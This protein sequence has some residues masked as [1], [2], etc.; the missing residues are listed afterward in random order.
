MFLSHQSLGNRCLLWRVYHVSSWLYFTRWQISPQPRTDSD[1]VC[2]RLLGSM[3]ATQWYNVCPSSIRTQ[4]FAI[5]CRGCLRYHAGNIL[6]DSG[7]LHNHWMDSD[8]LCGSLLG[9]TPATQLYKV[10]LCPIETQEVAFFGGACISYQAGDIVLNSGSLYNS[11][12]D[13]DT[14][15]GRSLGSTPATQWCMVRLCR[16]KAH[17]SANPSQSG[18][19]TK[20]MESSMTDSSTTAWPILDLI[21]GDCWPRCQLHNDIRSFPSRFVL[22]KSQGP[23]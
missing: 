18:L 16:I 13:F 2:G 14:L 10:H 11:S 8:T 3:L 5:F 17:E 7:L 15:W 6:L 4:E 22:I 9:S 21:A 23:R 20:V 1:S 12:L 19:S